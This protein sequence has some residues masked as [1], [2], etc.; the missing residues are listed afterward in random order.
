[1][2]EFSDIKL[3]T[4][5]SVGYPETNYEEIC[6]RHKNHVT[7]HYGHESISI[8]VNAMDRD[9]E[10]LIDMINGDTEN[11][12]LRLRIDEIGDVLQKHGL[13]H[14]WDEIK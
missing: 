9:I 1:M 2:N 10:S 4:L 5:N 8:L 12:Q 13:D 14:L 6:S 7:P 11:K 3:Y